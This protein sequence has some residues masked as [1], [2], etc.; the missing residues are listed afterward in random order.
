MENE[1]TVKTKCS[2]QD[3][4]DAKKLL[5]AIGYKEIM[6]VVEDDV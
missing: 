2:I 5:L 3:R 1:I 6:Q 4:E